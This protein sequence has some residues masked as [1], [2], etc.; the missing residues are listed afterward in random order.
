MWI[1]QPDEE[2]DDLAYGK[3]QGNIEPNP[4][5]NVTKV[6]LADVGLIS[7][8]E[9]LPICER[10]GGRLYYVLQLPIA[11]RYSDQWTSHISRF[12][13]C[14]LLGYGDH[15][16]GRTDGRLRELNVSVHEDGE[17]LVSPLKG[18]GR[19]CSTRVTFTHDIF[20]DIREVLPLI[21]DGLFRIGKLNEFLDD[22]YKCSRI[23]RRT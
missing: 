11:D 17:A 8:N 10:K 16:R 4:S 23:V 9:P 7:L 18:K 5:P 2:L 13:D 19:F 20:V 12:Q 15:E 21:K 14:K 1:L 3:R 6:V 22:N